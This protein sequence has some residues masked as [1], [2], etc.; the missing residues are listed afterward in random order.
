VAERLEKVQRETEELRIE[1]PNLPNHMI[2]EKKLHQTWDGNFPA[3]HFPFLD[4][5]VKS[6]QVFA[7][8][9]ITIFHA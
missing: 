7:G 5:E 2:V 9:S 3:S 1:F 6:I 8:K 4:G